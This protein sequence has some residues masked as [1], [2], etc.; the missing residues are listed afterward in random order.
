MKK[1]VM[2][3]T[4]LA[5]A[6]PMMAQEDVAQKREQK[7]AELLK[8]FP[9]PRVGTSYT[10]VSAADAQRFAQ[11]MKENYYAKRQAAQGK[12][13]P[14]PTSSQLV[15][16]FATTK[17]EPTPAQEVNYL[18]NI[19]Q[20]DAPTSFEGFEKVVPYVFE[21]RENDALLDELLHVVEVIQWPAAP[22][23]AL[24]PFVKDN[25]MDAEVRTSMKAKYDLCD[26]ENIDAQT[27]AEYKKYVKIA[28]KISHDRALERMGRAKQAN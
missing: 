10:D 8:P 21:A 24:Y 28:R 9:L 7:R 12:A 26:N 19:G 11:A 18:I 25:I 4:L 2:L 5:L 6:M 1:V 3:V 16:P 23:A 15:G 14:A 13:V 22:A 17:Q 20:I 27:L